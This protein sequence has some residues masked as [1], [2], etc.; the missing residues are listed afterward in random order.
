[1]EVTYC[2]YVVLEISRKKKNKFAWKILSK[3]GKSIDAVE[4]GVRVIESDANNKSVGIGGLPDK[5]GI[6][7]LDA[8]IMDHYGN[9]GSVVYLKEIKHAIILKK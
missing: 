1:M 9:C 2:K 6:V 8:C 7:T 3:N 4:A 5:N